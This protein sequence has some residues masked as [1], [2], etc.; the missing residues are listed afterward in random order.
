M[1]EEGREEAVKIKEQA[2]L[3]LGKV[4]AKHSFAEGKRTLRRKFRFIILSRVGRACG[5][6][7]EHDRELLEGKGGQADTRSGGPVP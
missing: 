1:E 5:E 4:L 6:D 3:L 7:A 2:I